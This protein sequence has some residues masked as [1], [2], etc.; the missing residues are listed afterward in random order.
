MTICLLELKLRGQRS[1][2]K[3][4]GRSAVSKTWSKSS[5]SDTNAL[6]IV[7]LLS[8]FQSN[9]FS[10]FNFE[11]NEVEPAQDCRQFLVE[12]QQLN[13]SLL[14]WYLPLQCCFCCYCQKV[15]D[16]VACGCRQ[17]SFWFDGHTAQ[18]WREG[19]LACTA[20]TF[21]VFTYSSCVCSFWALLCGV[22]VSF[23]IVVTML[24]WVKTEMGDHWWGMPPQYVTSHSGHVHLLK[25]VLAT[26]LWL[27]SCNTI[28]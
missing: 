20:S 19:S 17:E 11:I 27:G 14:V 5:S 2:F 12:T 16:A 22:M 9:I 18:A 1:K 8:Q 6:N 4:K 15:E 26:T 28:Q 24:L 7:N 21:A 25:W 13:M 10:D 23:G 3:V